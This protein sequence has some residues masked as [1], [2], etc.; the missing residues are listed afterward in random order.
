MVICWWFRRF[1]VICWWIRVFSVISSGGLRLLVRGFEHV[2][3]LSLVSQI[4][5]AQ[6]NQFNMH[7]HVEYEWRLRQDDM[8]ESDDDLDDKVR[9]QTWLPEQDTHH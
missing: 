2:D 7:V 8:Y 6:N 5:Q 3:G 9:D 1:S 4:N